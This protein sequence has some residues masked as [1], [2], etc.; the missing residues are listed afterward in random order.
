MEVSGQHLA[1]A[2]LYPRGKEPRLPNIQEAGWAPEPVWTQRLQEMFY[3]TKMKLD[4][5]P[6]QCNYLNFIELNSS[7]R[8]CSVRLTPEFA[9]YSLTQQPLITLHINPNIVCRT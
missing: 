3:G 2:A 7:E 4:A 6:A 5:D 1:P 9:V 8:E